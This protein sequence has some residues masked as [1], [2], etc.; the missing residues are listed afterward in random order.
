MRAG[1]ST[2]AIIAVAYNY[3]WIHHATFTMPLRAHYSGDVILLTEPPERMHPGVRQLNAEQR[4]TLVTMH[5]KCMEARAGCHPSWMVPVRFRLYAEHCRSHSLCLAVDFRDVVFQDDPFAALARSRAAA[6][7][8]DLQPFAQLAGSSGERA[9]AAGHPAP[10]DIIVWC[11]DASMYVRKSV[12]NKWWVL[13]C[14]GGDFYRN[15]SS[16]CVINAGTVMG[17]PAGFARLAEIMSEGC[18]EP[19]GENMTHGKDQALLMWAYY[20]TR[21]G[22]GVSAELQPRGRGLINTVRYAAHALKAYT[23]WR[24]RE[25]VQWPRFLPWTLCNDD[26][27]TVSAVVHQYD[28]ND[29]SLHLKTA[30]QSAALGW[31]LGVSCGWKAV[32]VDCSELQ[33][34]TERIKCHCCWLLSTVAWISPQMR[35]HVANRT[36][37][38]SAC[39]AFL[40]LPSSVTSTDADAAAPRV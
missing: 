27:T 29:V 36:T 6:R 19:S 3:S 2:N 25:S 37:S 20:A 30:L 28:A 21:L 17:T 1:G 4:V 34:S 5:D 12:Y 38:A 7:I 33:N 40:E 22:S 14:A 26:N 9:R 18:P 13:N 10:A 32:R 24:P 15:V 8:R 31:R 11:E 35:E 23:W 39:A 16:R